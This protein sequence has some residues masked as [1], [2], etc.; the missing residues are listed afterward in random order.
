MG[1]RAQNEKKFGSWDNLPGGGRRYR[2]EVRGR[3]GGLPNTSKKW[4]RTKRQFGFGRRS[5]TIMAIWSKSTR[6][7][8]WIKGT[9]K[10]RVCK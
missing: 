4:T 6:N 3:L 10:R 7:I 1:T 8:P 9:K 5:I 2:L